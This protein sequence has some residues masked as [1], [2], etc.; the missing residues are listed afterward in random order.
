MRCLL[1]VLILCGVLF[2]QSP[3]LA[4]PSETNDATKAI[5]AF[6]MDLY[7]Q[8]ASG[9]NNLF[10]SPYSIASALAMTYRGAKGETASEMAEALHFSDVEMALHAS[11]K[12]LQDRFNSIPEG[13][14]V[15]EAANRLWLDREEKLLPNYAAA[16]KKYYAGGVE[17]LNFQKDAEA[18]RVTINDWVAQKTRDKIKD[19]LHKGDVTEETRLVLTN[20]IYFKSAWREPFMESLTKEAPFHIGPNERENVPTMHR[21]NS[22]LYGEQPGLQL[23]KIPYRMPGFSLLVLLPRVNEASTQ[24]EE[25]EKLEKNLTAQ[26]LAEWTA[27]MQRQRVSLWLP[28]FKDEERYPLK[29]I[30]QK[31]GMKLAFT[32]DADFS[33]MVEEKK[34]GD[35]GGICV[36][37]VIH[38]AFI[39]LDEKGTEAAAATAVV[40]VT[41]ATAMPNPEEPIEFRA[42]H[43]F[44]YC[45]M[46]DQT[47]A[48]LFM[49]RLV[50]P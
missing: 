33:N 14:G 34:K 38:Q 39:E 7:H 45:L 15:L 20:A 25:L 10:F 6:A 17:Q 12:A 3:A 1:S 21:T 29:E 2:M 43:P 13:A 23:L 19:L 40:M 4:A 22:F 5:D 50:K 32:V 41:K 36:D 31:L 49:G 8:L 16:V 42:D 9:K 27:N 47:G 30:L 11:M 24:L 18:S 28:K 35:G 26:S 44:V 48:I 46:D 37:S